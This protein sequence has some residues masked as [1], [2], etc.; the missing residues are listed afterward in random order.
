VEQFPEVVIYQYYTTPDKGSSATT[1]RQD[2]NSGR[3]TQISY[4]QAGG[5]QDG[6]T[7]FIFPQDS[8]TV[9]FDNTEC[10]KGVPFT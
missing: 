5:V 9:P 10:G 8:G 2:I 7:V 1:G 3:F 6:T 4:D